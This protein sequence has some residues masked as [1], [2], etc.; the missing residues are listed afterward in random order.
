MRSSIFCDF[1]NETGEGGFE[2]GVAT[3]GAVAGEDDAMRCAGTEATRDYPR[4][5]CWPRDTMLELVQSQ[6][7]ESF[8][9][10]EQLNCTLVYLYQI[11]NCYV[12]T[13]LSN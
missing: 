2:E 8:Y 4:W 13:P 7:N 5:W 9:F 3:N 1:V 11:G 10:I 6:L 12:I